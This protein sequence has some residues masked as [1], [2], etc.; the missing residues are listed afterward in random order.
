LEAFDKETRNENI[1]VTDVDA[2]A[3]LFGKSRQKCFEILIYKV[4]LVM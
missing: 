2:S 1:D 4:F 3:D